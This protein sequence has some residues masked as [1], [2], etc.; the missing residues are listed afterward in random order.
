M[1]L[2]YIFHKHIHISIL[3]IELATSDIANMKI[4][5]LTTVKVEQYFNSFK[6]S[7]R[8]NQLPFFFF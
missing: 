7:L 4:V 5:P 6:S 8:P 1:C 3:G 2:Y